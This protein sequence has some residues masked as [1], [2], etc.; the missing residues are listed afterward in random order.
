MERPVSNDLNTAQ[1]LWNRAKVKADLEV[2]K[3]GLRRLTRPLPAQNNTLKRA[4]ANIGGLQREGS[5]DDYSLA[6]TRL[7]L[8]LYQVITT[9]SKGIH[10]TYCCHSMAGRNGGIDSRSRAAGAP[11]RISPAFQ[12]RTV[13]GPN[14]APLRGTRRIEA[15]DRRARRRHPGGR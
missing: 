10:K 1:G 4:R 12:S 15:A 6:E 7:A 9:K 5:T 11:P 2:V 13:F 14:R 8:I 3:Q